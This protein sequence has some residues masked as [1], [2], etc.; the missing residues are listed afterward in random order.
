[1][2]KKSFNLFAT[3][4]VQK[5]V[6]VDDYLMPLDEANRG[7]ASAFEFFLEYGIDHI[8]KVFN[9]LMEKLNAS[10]VKQDYTI[11]NGNNRITK[12]NIIQSILGLGH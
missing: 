4:V 11:L 3:V 9:R 2:K 7:Y 1:M 5:F 12:A 6:Y 8:S 10:R